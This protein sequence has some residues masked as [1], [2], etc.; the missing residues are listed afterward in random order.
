[1]KLAKTFKEFQ[2]SRSEAKEIVI[3]EWNIFGY[4]YDG[5]CYIEIM[6]GDG[7]QYRLQIATSEFM[8]NDLTEL[9]RRL[10]DDWYLS[11][12]ADGLEP[13]RLYCMAA[14]DKNH[15]NIDYFS[16]KCKIL[17]SKDLT[18]LQWAEINKYRIFD[19]KKGECFYTTHDVGSIYLM[20]LK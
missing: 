3:D 18:D 10:Y 14:T 13:G 17:D 15:V 11:E 1:M 19:L 5:D 2:A 6:G 20:R 7:L 16:F 9:E 4:E 12:C 8:S